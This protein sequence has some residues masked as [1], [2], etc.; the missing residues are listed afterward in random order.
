MQP[1]RT[2]VI[3]A[4]V[5]VF[6]EEGN[7]TAL[8]RRLAPALSGISL[9]YEIIFVDDGSTDGTFASVKKLNA[10]DRRVQGISFS[11]NFGHQTALLA[12]LRHASGRVTIT[13]DGDLQH[14]PELIPALY[15]KHL[16]GFD[17]VNTRRIDEAAAGLF[18]KLSSRLFYRLI[19]YLADVRIEPAAADFRLMSRAATDAFLSIPERDRFTRGLVSWMGFRQAVVP[20]QAEARHSGKTK[21]SL[22]KMLRFGLNGITSFSSRPLRLSFY[23]GIFISLAGL[24][25][26]IY[27]VVQFFSGQTIPGWTSILVSL[28][29]IGGVILINLGIIGEYIARIFNEVKARPLYFIKEQ[30]DLPAIE[31]TD[32]PYEQAE[33]KDR[34]P[35]NE[36]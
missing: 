21:Y 18:K 22:R 25:Y 29:I 7:T 10:A 1:N 30:T 20:Y 23:S 8:Y 24:A 28:L 5:P 3:S 35:E 27:A 9:H 36:R 32:T 13:L 33:E 34:R 15:A 4:V 6:N 26:S 19:N 31:Q 14:P 12:G 2:A 17:I 16:E 11:R